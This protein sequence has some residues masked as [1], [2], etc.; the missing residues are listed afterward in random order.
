MIKP[1]VLSK[2]Y[3]WEQNAAGRVDRDFWNNAPNNAIN[4]II[5][6]SNW[7]MNDALVSAE[8][9]GVDINVVKEAD[10]SRAVQSFVNRCPIPDFR[11]LPDVTYFT[12]GRFAKKA[13]GKYLK[14]NKIDYID[15]LGMPNGSHLLA[16]K[17]KQNFGLPWVARFYDPW[18]D[19]QQLRYK[20]NCSRR[21]VERMECQ[22]AE[23]ADIIIHNNTHIA[24][25]WSERY[26]EEV[27]KKIKVLPMV[28]DCSRIT[29][30]EPISHK[31][32]KLV[33]SHIGNLYGVRNAHNLILAINQLLSVHPELR[34]GI[35]VNMVGWVPNNDVNEISKLGLNDVFNLTGRISEAECTK[36][37]N[38]SD[39][40]ISIDGVGEL[41]LNY[42]S[43]LLKYFYFRRPI[44]G[45][46]LDNSV[47]AEE[48]DNSN[49]FH[50]NVQDIETIAS[51]IEKAFFNYD[52]L[53]RFDSQY[54][55]RFAPDAIINSYKTILYDSILQ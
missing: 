50:V 48:L 43:K 26:G 13:I 11:N 20:F 49:N 45:L 28:F 27:A 14:D 36:Y 24:K 3:L 39:L 16:L 21:A 17:I 2:D 33:I 12:W 31:K 54:F 46:T 22:V 52:D 5:Y 51:F 1:L 8:H 37:F 38:E 18:I 25:V 9:A 23:T 35:K 4:P 29:G 41:D 53:L 6:C 47:A 44:L 40:F 15:S 55:L 34:N 7:Q 19:N 42:P 30:Y 32:G 10:Y